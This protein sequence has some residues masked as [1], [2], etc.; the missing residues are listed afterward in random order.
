[1]KVNEVMT[2][3][4]RTVEPEATL[5]SAAA[6]MKEHNVGVLPVVT[7]EGRAVGTITDRDITVRGVAENQSPSETKVQDAMTAG[8]EFCYHDD[9]IE[10]LA[11]LM[12]EKKLHRLIVVDR[13]TKGI[14]GIVS[15]GDLALRGGDKN[16]AG[17]VLAECRNA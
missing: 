17:G 4:L 12:G 10:Q 3:E 1:M 5:Q 9:Q 16:I 13:S 7:P 11:R 15:V 2:P 6:I 8:I 14:K